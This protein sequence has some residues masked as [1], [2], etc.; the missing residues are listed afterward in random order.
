MK[1]RILGRAF[2]VL[3]VVALLPAV[4]Y[5][6]SEKAA[7][8]KIPV[9]TASAEARRHYLKGQELLDNLKFTDA[10]VQ[11]EKAV[12]AD[13]K[14][15]LGHLRLANSATSPESF[16][17]S[18]AEARALAG[19]VSEGERLWILATDA[20]ARGRAS[21]AKEI[22][23]RLAEAYPKD[24]RAHFLLGVSTMGIQKWDEA[25]AVFQKAVALNPDFASV[26][27]Q[28]G[29]AMRFAGDHQGAEEAFQKY[30]KLIPDDPNPYDSYA[31]LLLTLGRYEESIENY[32]KA[33]EQDKNFVFSHVGIATNL[34][35]QGKHEDAR[36]ELEKM[37]E[38]ART[39]G[40]RRA[41]RFAAV[42]SYVDEGRLDKAVEAMW[43]VHSI[44]KKNGNT[45][46][47]AQDLNVIAF[48]QLEAGK[49]REAQANYEKSV[50]MRVEA[51]IPESA[52]EQAERDRHSNGA[53]VAL[54]KGDLETARA[55][56]EKFRALAEPT[57]NPNQIRLYHELAG[58]IALAEKNYEGAIKELQQAN[59]QNPYNLYRLAVAYQGTGDKENSG[60]YCRQVKALNQLNSLN[61]GLVRKE[62]SRVL[63]SL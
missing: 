50:A 48:L 44:A 7:D 19:E 2:S 61:Y 53:R 10:R 20:G 35:L 47:M 56:A 41:A 37:Y 62:A 39:D 63:A 18:V 38:G 36:A 31:E 9:T 57:A 27:N 25:I 6:K 24:E 34:N 58:M 21:E 15:A 16:L 51:D 40:E 1:V 23:Q 54:K 13:P 26:Y 28:M 29:Y 43:A 60:Q 22:F 46:Q 14:F 33:L 3:L 59:Q 30:I 12:A 11:F 42:V 49:S 4:G 45:I 55:E 17:D 8:G 5:S 32:R 52:K